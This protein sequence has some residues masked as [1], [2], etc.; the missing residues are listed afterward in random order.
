MSVKD[1]TAKRVYELNLAGMKQKEIS[2]HLSISQ[3]TVSDILLRR[4]KRIV[5]IADLHSGHR[6]G[7]TPPEWQWKP[8]NPELKPWAEQQQEMWNTYVEIL[9]KLQPVDACFVLGDMIDGKGKKSESTELITPNIKYQQQMATEAIRQ[10]HAPR[11]IGVYGT[12]YHTGSSMDYER[13]VMEELENDAVTRISGQEFVDVNGITFDLKHHTSNSSTPHTKGTSLAKKWLWNVIWSHKRGQQPSA[14]IIL[15][16]HVHS[17]DY[18]GQRD[19]L[20]MTVPAL[21]GWGS[22][23]G[24]RQCDKTVDFGLT[25][26]DIPRGAEFPND[27]LWRPELPILQSQT[28]ES[29]EIT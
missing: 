2:E 29:Y 17:F 23:Y 15:R 8:D 18:V 13:E 27:V 24:K 26:F 16:A 6:A 5:V 14:D 25:W 1:S 21:Q 22:R 7:L 4:K 3:P 10:V 12:P 19:F 11:I 28:I 9:K 20:A